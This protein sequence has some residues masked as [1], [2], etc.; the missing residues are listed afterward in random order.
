MIIQILSAVFISEFRDIPSAKL[1]D[2]IS[3]SQ[4]IQ[5]LKDVALGK[6]S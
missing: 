3:E 4:F 6:V 1:I 5:Q 2:M